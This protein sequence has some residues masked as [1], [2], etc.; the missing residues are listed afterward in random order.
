MES[1]NWGRNLKLK[2]ARKITF[3]NS[4]V[5]MSDAKRLFHLVSFSK[6]IHNLDNN[7]LIHKAY[8][9]VHTHMLH[10]CT[11]ICTI[12]ASRHI[13]TYLRINRM[14]IEFNFFQKADF[15][16]KSH[17]Q[18]LLLLWQPNLTL[19]QDLP[20]LIYFCVW[21]ASECNQVTQKQTLQKEISLQ[22]SKLDT[23]AMAYPGRLEVVFLLN[24]LYT[25]T[26]LVTMGGCPR[27]NWS[28]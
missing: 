10:L 12:Q 8:V 27:S 25:A 4:Q 20:L 2:N 14:R 5:T 18:S 11:L 28:H 26:L 6:L 15:Y 16:F 23:K 13:H 22:K 17:K 9:I 1:K 21:R 7:K 24:C 19:R 3:P